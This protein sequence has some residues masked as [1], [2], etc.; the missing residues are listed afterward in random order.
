MG[1]KLSPSQNSKLLL[2]TLT[3]STRFSSLNKVQTVSSFLADKPTTSP[4]DTRLFREISLVIEP[5]NIANVHFKII[6]WDLKVFWGKLK[7]KRHALNKLQWFSSAWEARDNV[8]FSFLKFRV[9]KNTHKSLKPRRLWFILF[10][11]RRI[12]NQVYTK[13]IVSLMWVTLLNRRLHYTN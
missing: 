9:T 1:R 13:N 4:M 7:K 12:Y 8:S 6:R 5:S 2:D 10:W 3:I 11:K